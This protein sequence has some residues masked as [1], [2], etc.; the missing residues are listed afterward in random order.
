[1]Q[2]RSDIDCIAREVES[3]QALR[4]LREAAAAVEEHSDPVSPRWM[5][6]QDVAVQ[7]V[8]VS[9]ACRYNSDWQNAMATC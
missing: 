7:G 5:S 1:V 2:L 6:L 4:D 9:L 3:V 8:G